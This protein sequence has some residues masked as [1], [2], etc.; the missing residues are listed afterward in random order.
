[1]KSQVLLTVWCNISGEAAGEIWHWSLSGVKGL[2]NER[3]RTMKLK[4]R[5]I[6][7]HIA[8]DQV[9]W[10]TTS[11]FWR[12]N[13]RVDMSILNSTSSDEYPQFHAPV[14]FLSSVQRRYGVANETCVRRKSNCWVCAGVRFRATGKKMGDS[15]QQPGCYLHFDACQLRR[16]ASK[17]LQCTQMLSH[18]SQI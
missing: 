3:P 14:T 1:M 18:L 7:W 9:V 13:I 15:S 12:P 11:G 4:Q 6:V 17:S 2:V 16:D 8:H 10:Q 5:N